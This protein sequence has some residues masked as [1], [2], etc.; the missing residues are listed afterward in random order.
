MK[1]A[2]RAASL[3][4]VA[5]IATACGGDDGAG[6]PEAA[7][8]E[9]F[10]KAWSDVAPHSKEEEFAEAVKPVGTPEDIPDDARKG[11]ELLIDHTKDKD[12]YSD[13][14]FAQYRALITYYAK[15]CLPD[16]SDAPTEPSVEQ[17]CK[18]LD[19]LTADAKVEGAVDGLEAADPP[20]DIPDDARK[21]F[22]FLV[23]NAEDLDKNIESLDEQ[24]FKDKYGDEAFAQVEALFEY[25]G[26]TC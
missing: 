8:V 26:K 21:G 20:E 10:C 4:L 2:L 17:F 12:K 18:S 5:G 16:L 25:Y 6:A 3:L 15:T 14:E 19:E 23:D 11:F 7:S 22:E 13:Q 9:E 1:K 24:G